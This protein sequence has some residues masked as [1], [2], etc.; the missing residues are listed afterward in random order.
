M[1]YNGCTT[2]NQ[3]VVYNIGAQIANIAG[4]YGPATIK[5][6]SIILLFL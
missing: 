3:I 4:T 5:V 1:Q 6:L 2:I